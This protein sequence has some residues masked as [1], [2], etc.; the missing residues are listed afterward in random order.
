M[1]AL[2][3]HQPRLVYLWAAD[4]T[5]RPALTQNRVEMLMGSQAEFQITN[6]DTSFII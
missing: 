4:V 6:K 5:D 2:L 3:A 1:A